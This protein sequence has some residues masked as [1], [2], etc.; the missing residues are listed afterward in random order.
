MSNVYFVLLN[1]PEVVFNL[2]FFSKNTVYTVC[3]LKFIV[4]LTST[5]IKSVLKMRNQILTA[6]LKTNRMNQN[7][8][9][10]LSSLQC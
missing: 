9:K 10:C 8:K 5:E 7:P 2:L 1:K 6:V 4:K 3:V